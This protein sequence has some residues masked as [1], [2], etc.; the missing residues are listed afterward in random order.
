MLP[1]H[2]HLIG[3]NEDFESEEEG[4]ETV[5]KVKVGKAIHEASF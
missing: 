2:T 5:N 1:C 3:V 4:I